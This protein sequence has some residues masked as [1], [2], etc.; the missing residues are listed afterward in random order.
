[1]TQREKILGAA[2][3]GV[4]LLFAGQMVWSNIQAGFA[5]KEGTIEAL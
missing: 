2:V 4:V 1:M 3:A 5:A